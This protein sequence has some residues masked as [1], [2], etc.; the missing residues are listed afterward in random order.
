MKFFHNLG[1]ELEGVTQ[2]CPHSIHSLIL[3]KVQRFR[4]V[5]FA[6]HTLW[7]SF[8]QL[9]CIIIATYMSSNFTK[10][11]NFCDFLFLPWITSC[12]KMGSALDEKNLLP[13]REESA[14]LGANPSFTSCPPLRRYKKCRVVAE[15]VPIPILATAILA[16]HQIDQDTFTAISAVL[17]LYHS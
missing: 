16:Y 15:W 3:C 7:T 10:G 1:Q 13:R 8:S 14:P 4:G 9:R 6:K 2:L 17:Q 12:S 11:N 5:F